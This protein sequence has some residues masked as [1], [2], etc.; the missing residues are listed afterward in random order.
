MTKRKEK[1]S[2]SYL[3]NHVSQLSTTVR[4]CPGQSVCDEGK[5]G[6]SWAAA[7][8]WFPRSVHSRF[9]MLHL[10]LYLAST[11]WREEAAKEAVHIKAAW[12]KE[13]RGQAS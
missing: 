5:L 10:G 6:S 4:K 2:C 9:I 12:K 3:L 13:K 8:S 7:V 1:V 11:S